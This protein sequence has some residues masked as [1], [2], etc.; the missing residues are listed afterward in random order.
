MSPLNKK[1]IR[2]PDPLGAGLA[3]YRIYGYRF[4]DDPTHFALAEVLEERY[5]A[6]LE[7]DARAVSHVRACVAAIKERGTLPA[8]DEIVIRNVRIDLD[9]ELDARCRTLRQQPMI[10]PRTV[11]AIVGA[12]RSGT[13]HLF[14]LLAKDGRFAY[15]TTASCWKWPTYNLERPGRRLFSRLSPRDVE[16][17]LSVDNA[18]TRSIP[19]LVMPWEAEDT[20]NRSHPVYSHPRWRV[21]DL[22]EPRPGDVNLLPQTV[23]DHL[24]FFGLRDFLTKS[25][26]N[27]LR[28][29][30][31]E[32]LWGDRMRYLHIVRDQAATADSLRRHSIAFRRAGRHL[33]EEDA[34]SLFIDTA[35]REL[36]PDRSLHLS[37]SDLMIKPQQTIDTV[38]SWLG[39]PPPETGTDRMAGALQDPR[40]TGKGYT[41]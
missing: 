11:I 16:A 39:L 30:H 26:Y 35:R 21:Y 9:A 38:S 32:Q 12:P 27:T 2:N 18:T 34:W 1:N 20:N 10:L 41:A 28:I 8:I 23:S 6:D 29:R 19:A 7:L 31:L 33:S 13:T 3:F 5:L 4:T 17:V 36:P 40:D 25:P 14:N 24:H 37:F 22:H 15:F